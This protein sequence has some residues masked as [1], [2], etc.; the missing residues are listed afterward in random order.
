[1][2][3]EILSQVVNLKQQRILHEVHT[4]VCMLVCIR[5]YVRIISMLYTYRLYVPFSGA[6]GQFAAV[7]RSHGQA[8]SGFSKPV[9][10]CSPCK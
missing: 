2:I 10:K 7:D 4:Y 3:S 6:S 8:R 1:M 9:D 5:M